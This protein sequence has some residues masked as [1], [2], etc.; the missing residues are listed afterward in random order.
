MFLIM[1][2]NEHFFLL[3]EM[4]C[5]FLI[6]LFHIGVVVHFFFAAKK[7]SILNTE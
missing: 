3:P 7:I 1:L 5:I 4:L 2:C 6:I